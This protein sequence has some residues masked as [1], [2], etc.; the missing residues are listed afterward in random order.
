MDYLWS[1]FRVELIMSLRWYVVHV[2]S[3]MEKK[4]HAAL[5]ERIEQAGMQEYFGRIL[6]PTEEIVET[7]GS[8][9]SVSQRKIFPGYILV[10]MEFNNDTWHLVKSTNRV[11]GFLGGGSNSKPSPIPQKE[12]DS[13]L[14][15]LE[16]GGGKPRPKVLFEVG[17]TLRIKDGPFADFNGVVDQVNYEK[18]RVTV[19]VMIFGRS[20]PVELDFSQ[21]EKEGI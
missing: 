12:V 9:R 1:H 15:N 6:V 16:E 13:L 14:S 18:N 3:G 10:E 20:T 19:I 5:Q 11:T 8:K 17:E 21:V 4:V 7:R 2:F